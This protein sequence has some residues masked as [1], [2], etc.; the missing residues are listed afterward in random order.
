MRHLTSKSSLSFFDRYDDGFAHAIPDFRRERRSIMPSIK[1]RNLLIENLDEKLLGVAGVDL[2]IGEVFRGSC[3][4]RIDDEE[5]LSQLV[6]E[7]SLKRVKPR[8]GKIVLEPSYNGKNVYFV[9]SVERIS[10]PLELDIVVD[11]RSTAGRLGLL[12]DDVS[13]RS[14]V[15]ES[16]P[17]IVGVRSYAFPVEIEQG[18]SSIF[19][20]I[21][22]YKDSPYMTQEQIL[23]SDGA[24]ELFSQKK[25]LSLKENRRVSENGLYISFSTGVICRARKLKEIQGPINID[26]PAGGY[27][28]KDY[29]DVL[30]GNDEFLME[31]KRF[32]L[33]G[34]NER[35]SLGNVLGVISRDSP[36]TGTGLWGHFAGNIWPGFNGEITMECRSETPRVIVSGDYAGFISF[37]LLESK[38]GERGYKGSYQN[39]RAPR[40]PKMFK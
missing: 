1:E 13:F 10:L 8:N 40:A 15:F 25:K 23:S 9:K 11:A 30:G 2:R 35:V 37:D 5:H 32:Y 17:V 29:F 24:I 36:K 3:L 21:F 38:N 7:G 27:E 20:G 6:S 34:T 22:R 12:C 14:R 28:T 19:Q 4:R 39:Q 26:A 33:L 18:K 16:N 31:A